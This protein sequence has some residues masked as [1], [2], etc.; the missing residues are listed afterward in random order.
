[1]NSNSLI[2][3]ARKRY[4]A[5]L[6]SKGVLSVDS[7]GVASNADKNNNPSVRIAGYIAEIVGAKTGDKLEGQKLGKEFEIITADFIS[8]SFLL[9]EH[10]RPASWHILRE[11]DKGV[12]LSLSCFEQY[13]HLEELDKCIEESPKL[14]AILG[15]DYLVKPDIIIYRDTLDDEEINKSLR[16]ESKLMQTKGQFWKAQ[17]CFF[18]CTNFDSFLNDL[19]RNTMDKEALDALFDKY[20]RK[21]RITPEWDIK[22]ELVEDPTWNKTGDFKI[23]CDDRK[24]IL[25][26]NVVNPK[27]ENP[28]RSVQ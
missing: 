19:W 3:Q 16:K 9:L 27:Q 8:E 24:A 7:K 11:S 13:A 26:L 5:E 22:L 14:A 18:V 28:D 12:S 4:H 17:S 6:I 23:D 10:I 15:N 21:L 20:I 25:L 2:F 1:M